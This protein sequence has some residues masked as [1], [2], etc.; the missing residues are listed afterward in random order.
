MEEVIKL[1]NQL[2]FG[3]GIITGVIFTIVGAWLHMIVEETR[4]KK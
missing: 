1:V 4:H 3:M 2:S